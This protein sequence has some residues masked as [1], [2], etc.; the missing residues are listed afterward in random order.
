MPTGAVKTAS[1]P[2]LNP[3]GSMAIMLSI[4]DLAP[5]LPHARA[6]ESIAMLRNTATK[7]TGKLRDEACFDVGC[8]RRLPHRVV[9]T[10]AGTICAIR[11]SG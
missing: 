11:G 8:S 5:D 6:Q 1:A 3:D 4:H 9:G 7:L 2:V 10:T